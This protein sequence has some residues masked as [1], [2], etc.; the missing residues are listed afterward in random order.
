MRAS[1]HI[2][3]VC[4]QS[5]SVRF[6]VNHNNFFLY[7]FCCWWQSTLENLQALSIYS[8]RSRFFNRTLA[9]INFDTQILEFHAPKL[10]SFNQVKY[11]YYVTY[12]ISLS[13]NHFWIVVL[14][15]RTVC[16]NCKYFLV[17]TFTKDV[18]FLFAQ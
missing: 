12:G 18:I 6:C 8:L 3:F 1:S 10:I 14:V 15:L 11:S 9:A 5:P 17:S 13:K 16:S 2:C 4:L 7:Y